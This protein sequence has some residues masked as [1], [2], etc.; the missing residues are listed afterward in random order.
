MARTARD[1]AELLK[2]MVGHDPSDPSMIPGITTLDYLSM[3]T[4]D[5]SGLT[6]GVE[7]SNHLTNPA[8]DPAL[9]DCFE[10]A[11]AVLEKGGATIVEVTMPYYREV[12]TA[13]MVTLQVE[14]FAYHHRNLAD[15]W[16]D[17]GRGTRASIG[18]AALLTAAD[19]AQGQKA[20]RLARAAL[21]DLFTTVDL[22]V[23][24]TCGISAPP[25]E[26]LSM[27]SLLSSIYTQYWNSVG[28]PALSVPMGGNEAGMPLGLQIAGRPLE[29]GLVLRAGDAFQ[30][31]TD[32]HLQQ[33]PAVMDAVD[34]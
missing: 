26:T 27:E 30:R 16:N 15:R 34:H 3:L 33:P 10:A 7:R 5:L 29:D 32:F 2:V 1:C 24:P 14:A 8:N 9:A 12:S 25:L 19:Y 11:V 17:Y 21:A 28:N 13:T 31:L 22:I 4:G 18:A 23:T 6:I 20:R